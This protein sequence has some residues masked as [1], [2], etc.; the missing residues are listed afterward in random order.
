MS[1]LFR[2][3]SG[4]TNKLLLEVVPIFC[5]E[6]VSTS[7]TSEVVRKDKYPKVAENG[8]LGVVC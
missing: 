2:H 3:T 7:A 8:F 6:V 4:Y 5:G 1:I